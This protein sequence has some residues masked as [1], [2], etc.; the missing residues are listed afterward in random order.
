MPITRDITVVVA[1]EEGGKRK[2][3]AA[4]FTARQSVR[5]AELLTVAAESTE[6][7][8]DQLLL[9]RLADLF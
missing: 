4:D 2:A 9:E 1:K 8:S 5:I 3:K 7:E 6:D